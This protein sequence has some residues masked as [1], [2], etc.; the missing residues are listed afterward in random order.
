[1]FDRE[2]LGQGHGVRFFA[3]MEFDCKC[4]NLQTTFFIFL[5]F[6]MVRPVRMKVTY[7]HRHRS[8]HTETD[9]LI[10]IGKI[11]QMCLK[12]AHRSLQHSTW[13]MVIHE[14]LERLKSE[15]DAQEAPV[16]R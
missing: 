7:T 1:M 15:F 11:L 9:K 14:L 6:A 5:I 10:A 16:R 13:S 8:T 2:N 3:M 12:T 4:Q